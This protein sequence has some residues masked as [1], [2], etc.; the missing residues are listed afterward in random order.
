[1]DFYDM[2]NCYVLAHSFGSLADLWSAL[3]V[4]SR[5]LWFLWRKQEHK[6][7]WDTAKEKYNSTFTIMTTRTLEIVKDCS[8]SVWWRMTWS[9]LQD[10]F[11]FW[12][13]K[14]IDCIVENRFS[15]FMTHFVK[16]SSSRT[17]THCTNVDFFFHMHAYL[18]T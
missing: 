12:S 1:M 14:Y 15:H 10:P 18:H 5:L 16:H 13:I 9:R 17:H 7:T 11:I 3:L 8:L 4:S 6:S 2:H